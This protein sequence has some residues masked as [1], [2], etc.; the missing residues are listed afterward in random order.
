MKKSCA[1][2]SNLQTSKE[3]SNQKK[4]V[5]KVPRDHT[6]TREIPRY[7]QNDEASAAMSKASGLCHGTKK[8]EGKGE[9]H[10]KK[11]MTEM[12]INRRT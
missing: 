1:K 2:T 5:I 7:K 12:M 10:K 11:D 4:E 6:C 9:R 3:V 8:R